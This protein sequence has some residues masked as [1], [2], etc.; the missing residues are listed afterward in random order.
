MF[1]ED[2]GETSGIQGVRASAMLA[3]YVVESRA[4]PQEV[5]G[6]DA[7]LTTVGAPMLYLW[8]GLGGV[9]GDHSQEVTI[10]PPE[11][12]KGAQADIPVDKRSTLKGLAGACG[13][14]LASLPECPVEVREEHLFRPSQQGEGGCSEAVEVPGLVKGHRSPGKGGKE[15]GE[16][17]QGVAIEVGN[18]DLPSLGRGRGRGQ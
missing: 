18:R 1:G 12:A 6:A 7:N 8:A 11:T 16:R 3:P 17:P 14:A 4:T 10:D 9:V 5:A 13:K 15:Q 2:C